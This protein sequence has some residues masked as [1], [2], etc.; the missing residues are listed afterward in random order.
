MKRISKD[1]SMGEVKC[2]IVGVTPDYIIIN[3]F[4]KSNFLKMT[5]VNTIRSEAIRFP[6]V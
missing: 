3:H 6:L 4:V 5:S 1:Q 2:L